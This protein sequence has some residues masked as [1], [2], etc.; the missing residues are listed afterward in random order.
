MHQLQASKQGGTP[1]AGHWLSLHLCYAAPFRCPPQGAPATP[2]ACWP[3]HALPL[4]RSDTRARL[5]H[6]GLGGTRVWVAHGC[7]P[8]AAQ[9]S[10]CLS[11]TVHMQAGV[12]YAFW[13]AAAAIAEHAALR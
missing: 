3:R 5:W 12:Q 1:L 6:T 8:A 13:S 10:S 9:S 2:G 11:V 4:G 7:A